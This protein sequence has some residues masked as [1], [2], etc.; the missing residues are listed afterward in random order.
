MEDYEREKLTNQM[1]NYY[2]LS[3]KYKEYANACQAAIPCLQSA[4]SGASFL[5]D[6]QTSNVCNKVKMGIHPSQDL[7]N[8]LCLNR[9]NLDTEIDTVISIV[10]DIYYDA[11]QKSIDYENSAVNIMNQLYWG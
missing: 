8:R 3:E 11:I 1:N 5:Y 4:K 2:S 7:L 6:S 10:E 9:R